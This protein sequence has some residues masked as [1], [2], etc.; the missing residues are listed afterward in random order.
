MRY[1]VAIVI[2]S[3]CGSCGSGA[4]TAPA[5]AKVEPVKI[6]QFY[7]TD[8][9][10]PK[11]VKG[12]LCYGVEHAAK[13]ELAPPVEDV[14]PA[15]TRCF[16]ISP[17]EN[18]RYTL[19]AVGDNGSRDAKTVDITVG[20]APP[21]LYDLSVNATLVRAGEQVVV[22]FKVEN[23]TSVKAGP[24]HFDAGA[25]CITDRPTKT[26]RYKISALGGDRQI[27]TGTVTVKVKAQ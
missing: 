13:V 9:K 21:R 14:W 15:A 23:A 20:A 18:T 19:T 2:A 3:L 27:D 1:P 12:E 25:N 5:K 7:A 16:E 17:R 22:C 10:V 26:T 8:K 11:G 24:G 4:A 6:T